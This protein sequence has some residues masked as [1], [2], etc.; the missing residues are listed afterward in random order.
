MR[1][2]RLDTLP[3]YKRRVN[4][5]FQNYSLF[6]HLTVQE[7]V[8]YGLQVSGVAKAEIPGRVTNALD[9]GKMQ[10]FATARPANRTDGHQQRLALAP[11]VVNR[12]KLCLLADPPPP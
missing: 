10:E 12:P 9:M 1:G 4:T 7:N 3:P 2:E 11:A 8:G 5:V 6:P